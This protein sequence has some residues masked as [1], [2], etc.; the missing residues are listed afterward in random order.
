MSDPVQA[1]ARTLERTHVRTVRSEY[2][3][4]LSKCRFFSVTMHRVSKCTPSV[5]YAIMLIQVR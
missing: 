5:F 4:P 2:T 3:M 1:N